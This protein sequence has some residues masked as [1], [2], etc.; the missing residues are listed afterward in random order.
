M[1]AY[2]RQTHA[3]IKN[4]DRASRASNSAEGA[5]ERGRLGR[6]LLRPEGARGQR[7]ELGSNRSGPQV[8]ADVP[9]CTRRPRR[10]SKK[11]DAAG[12]RASLIRDDRNATMKSRAGLRPRPHGFGAGWPGQSS[13]GQRRSRHR[14]QLHPRR[15]PICIFGGVLKDGG[16]VGKFLHRREPADDRQPD[17]HP[18]QPRHAVF[19]GGVRPRRRT[20][21][22]SPCRMPASVS[23]R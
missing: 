9:T 7:V 12:R 23:C 10:C 21:H 14:R 1:T 19:V 17:R 5:E 22:A 4:V 13:S 3:L 18:P 2:D 15:G 6:P 16:A 20:G 11:L 8:R